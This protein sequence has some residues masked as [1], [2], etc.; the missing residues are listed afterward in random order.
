MA[1]RFTRPPLPEVII[2]RRRASGL[3]QVESADLIH[4]SVDAYRAYE[5]GRR[6][7]DLTTWELFM[8]KTEGY[9]G[10]AG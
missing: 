6:S 3:T 5:R 2:A 9:C 1:F 4:R 8:I 7:M 10:K